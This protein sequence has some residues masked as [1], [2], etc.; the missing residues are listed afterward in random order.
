M[1]KNSHGKENESCRQR[2]YVAVVRSDVM[3][4]SHFIYRQGCTQDILYTRYC[5]LTHQNSN[6]LLVLRACIFF[7]SV[8]DEKRL[9]TIKFLVTFKHKDVM[10][11]RKVGRWLLIENYLSNLQKVWVL[12][13][14]YLTRSQEMENR[15]DNNRGGSLGLKVQRQSA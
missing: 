11:T 5:I 1:N 10:N 9:L 6:L 14:P 13:R 3:F 2:G 15:K 12:C 8:L 4:R 7:L